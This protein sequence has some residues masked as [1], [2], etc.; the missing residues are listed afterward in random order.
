MQTLNPADFLD[1]SASPKQSE[2]ASSAKIKGVEAD[3]ARRISDAETRKKQAEA[4]IINATSLDAMRKARADADKAEADAIA[5]KAA[6]DAAIKKLQG[7]EK[8]ATEQT[9]ETRILGDM[10]TAVDAINLLTKLFNENL[11]GSGPV[12]ST[13]EYF[14]TQA[15]A[16]TF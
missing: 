4:A 14:P 6:A 3:F 7:P 15:K 13:L 8:T 2:A 9:A 10:N 5:A 16:Q 12:K 11:A 1:T